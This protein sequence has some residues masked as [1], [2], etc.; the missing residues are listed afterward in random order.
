MESSRYFS[1]DPAVYAG[2]R[3]TNIST[4]FGNSAERTGHSAY[5]FA[6]PHLIAAAAALIFSTTLA[7]SG[8]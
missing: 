6:G 3:G 8:M 2:F 7:A 5:A 1:C 4:R